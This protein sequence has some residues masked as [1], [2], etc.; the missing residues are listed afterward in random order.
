MTPIVSTMVGGCSRS[1]SQP[2]RLAPDTTDLGGHQWKHRIVLV[3]TDSDERPE[4]REF[5]GAWSREQEDVEDRD[6]VVF[7]ALIKGTS[8]GPGGLL[9]SAQAD[10]LRKRFATAGEPF[11]VVLIGKDGG[12]K[13]RSRSASVAQIFRLIDTMPTRR[14]EMRQR[15]EVAQDEIHLH[16]APAVVGP[17]RGA[18]SEDRNHAP[19]SQIG[20][21]DAARCYR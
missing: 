15:L 1:T 7:E 9:T 4:F 21:R 19:L 18:C 14:A 3:F 2:T 16:R 20:T 17:L 13:L 10:D 11:E 5:M 6:L 12:V 8:R